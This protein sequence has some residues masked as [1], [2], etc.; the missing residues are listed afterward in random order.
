M[1]EDDKTVPE[2]SEEVT[3]KDA[4]ITAV[5]TEEEQA[6]PPPPPGVPVTIDGKLVYAE[7]G[8]LLIEAAERVG[9]HIP[10]FCYHE[11]L[12]PV[13]MCRMC[14]VEVDGGRGPMLSPACLVECTPDMKVETRSEKA[15]KAQDGVIEFLLVNHPLDCPVCD[16]GGECPLQDNT[17]AF[18]PAESRMV[19]E[20]RHREKPI[21]LSDLVLLDRERC[22]LCDRCTRFADEVAGDPLIHFIQRGVETEINTFP[23]EPFASYFSGN[24]VQLCPVGALTA[25]PYR[26]RARPWDIDSVES[27]CMTCSVG[28]RIG[29]QSSGRD[30]TRYIGID[31]DPVNHSWLCDKG[32]FAYEAI[33]NNDA[34]VSAPMVRKH[35]ELVEVSWGEAL[36][37]AAEGIRDAIR[38]QGPSAVGII[39]GAR[40]TNEDAFAWAKLA[41]DV[42]KTTNVD[43]QLDDGLPAEIVLGLPKATIDE[44]CEAPVVV[45]LAPDI[46]QELP[47]LFLRLRDSVVSG[48]TK[49]VE[50]TPAG[51]SFTQH[52][53]VSLGYR[54]GDVAAVAAALLDSAPATDIG[55]V[56]AASIESARAL[57]QTPGAVVILGR[58][59]TA[60][61]HNFVAD[62][63]AVLAAKLPGAKFLSAL[64]RANVHG[65]LAAGLRPTGEGMDTGAMLRA[66]ANGRLSTLVLLGADPASDV[67]DAGLAQRGLAGAGFT[68]AVT[69]SPTASTNRADVVLPAATFAEK[70]GTTTNIE[71]RVT[72][73]GQKV[74]PPGVAWEDWMIAAELAVALGGDLGFETLEDVAAAAGTDVDGVRGNGVVLPPPV[75]TNAP[76]APAEIP[77]PTLDNYSLRLV[78]GHMLYDEG[79]A[80]AASASLANLKKSPVLRANPRDLDRLGVTTG[81]QVRISGAHASFVVK[82][83]ADATVPVG[84]AWM[85]ANVAA[86]D[87]RSLIDSSSPVTDVRIENV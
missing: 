50:L 78:A 75:M 14:L 48:K 86:D 53:A 45:L 73:L 21:P 59:S 38:R 57:V 39:G 4:E 77:V 15:L 60:E 44:A 76:A 61:A 74:T 10:R 9:S 13:G 47:V 54:P 7:K 68:I 11:R 20:K 33:N 26:F 27:T 58:P 72:T 83:A 19:E 22:I 5:A 69:A 52:A 16:K 79:N 37:A 6:P 84:S 63:A 43:C 62:A 66:A 70:A 55:P 82:V 67:P 1:A 41:S 25:K 36:A 49:L 18:G 23:D 51:T 31:S 71:G 64:R 2:S 34:R 28:C 30:V 32:R 65:A 24:T 81:G 42:I 46:K 29:V 17:I 8:E 12:R 85:P 3:E 56:S 80:V 87:A 40:L 35:G